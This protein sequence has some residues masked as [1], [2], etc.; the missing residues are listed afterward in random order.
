MLSD[1]PDQGFLRCFRDPIRVPRI[2]E[3]YHRVPGIRENRVPKIRESGPYRVPNIFLEKKPW[4]YQQVLAKFLF[5][6]KPSLLL[7]YV[8]I[9]G[10]ICSNSRRM[11]IDSNTEALVFKS[12]LDAR[13]GNSD[14]CPS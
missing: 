2:S 9:K 3:N 4:M 11:H 8:A 6:D 7:T 1:V 13:P 5:H 10:V 14:F 12:C